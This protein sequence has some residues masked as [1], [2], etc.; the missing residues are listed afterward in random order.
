MRIALLGYQSLRGLR[1][2]EH[3]SDPVSDLS[4]YDLAV[5][6]GYRHIL[7]QS[8]LDTAKRPVLNLHIAYLPFN[9]GAHPNFWSWYEGTPAGVTIHEIDAGVDTGP[10]IY[11]RKL[12]IPDMTL[13]ESHALLLEEMER[14]FAENADSLL[15]GNYTAV[16][17]PLEGTCHR[18]RDLPDWV[19]WGMK[20]SEVR[21]YGSEPL[22]QP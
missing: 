20:I 13:R 14:L 4:E 22:A 6:F 10:I 1:D 7:K 15:S 18:V 17:Q 9:R 19:D 3:I 2:A 11:Q 5:S 21:E 12:N 8:V 16:P